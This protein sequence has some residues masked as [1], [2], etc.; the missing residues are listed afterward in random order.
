MTQANQKNFSFPTVV[1]PRI[2]VISQRPYNFV[3]SVKNVSMLL[4][5]VFVDVKMSGKNWLLLVSIS[6]E[7]DAKT[8]LC[9]LCILFF[10]VIGSEREFGGPEKCMEGDYVI[11][12]AVYCGCL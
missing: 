12:K 1:E 7:S 8:V 10:L 11:T 4:G 9:I 6:L 3:L 5:L 2:R